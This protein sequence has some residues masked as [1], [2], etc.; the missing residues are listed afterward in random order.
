MSAKKYKVVQDDFY[1]LVLPKHLDKY[2]IFDNS[3]RS[4]RRL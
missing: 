1:H 2:Y 3:T 4:T